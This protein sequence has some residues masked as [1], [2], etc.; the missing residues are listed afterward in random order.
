MIIGLIGC[1]REQWMTNPMGNGKT[2]SMTWFGYMDFLEGR[3]VVSNYK[4]NFSDMKTVHEMVDLF[5][6]TDLQNI[7]LLIDEIHVIYD[8][9]G[10]KQEKNRFI[11]NMITQTR[12]RRVDLY[13]TC[14]RW[15]SVNKT[16]RE[17]T[18]YILLPY[19][20]HP[21]TGE[22]CNIDTCEEEHEIVITCQVP[23][24]PWPLK[25]LNCEAVGALYD[26]NQIITEKY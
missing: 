19:K 6:E 26:S 17:M 3:K 2:M 11:R 15:M 25:I 14:Q 4:T 13:Y 9:L 24:K 16:L 21:E 7:T 5:N 18:T 10:H 20:T 23:L 8:S 22:L 12:K 1:L